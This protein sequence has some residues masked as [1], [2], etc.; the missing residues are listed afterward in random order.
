[1]VVAK[2]FGVLPYVEN[3]RRRQRAAIAPLWD[4]F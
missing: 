3:F 1:M 4:E 2:V